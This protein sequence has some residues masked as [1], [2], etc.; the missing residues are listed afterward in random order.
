MTTYGGV[1]MNRHNILT[2]T[3]VTTVT[4]R[5]MFGLVRPLSRRNERNTTLKGVT[6]VTVTQTLLEFVK[7]NGG[8]GYVF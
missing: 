5:N 6:L 7:V 3:T 4:V 2:V 1:T 8:S